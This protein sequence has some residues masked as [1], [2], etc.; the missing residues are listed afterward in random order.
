M[1]EFRLLSLKRLHNIFYIFFLLTSLCC[2]AT[3]TYSITRM[4]RTFTLSPFQTSFQVLVIST[5]LWAIPNESHVTTS[6]NRNPNLTS[7]RVFLYNLE[8]LL[9]SILSG[10]AAGRKFERGMSKADSSVGMNKVCK[11]KGCPKTG[12]H[13]LWTDL[14]RRL[15]KFRWSHTTRVVR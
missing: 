12:A 7:Q 13:S 10:R 3:F 9:I 15:S 1:F 11:Y 6:E 2:W 8:E 5:I 4:P 14:Q